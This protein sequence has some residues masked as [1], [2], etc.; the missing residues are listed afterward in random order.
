M[1]AAQN[2]EVAIIPVTSNVYMKFLIVFVS[3]I[4]FVAANVI[5]QIEKLITAIIPSNKKYLIILLFL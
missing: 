5:A 1:Y 2:N 3:E 4:N